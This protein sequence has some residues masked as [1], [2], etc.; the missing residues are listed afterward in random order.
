MARA[1]IEL[2]PFNG[3]HRSEPLVVMPG[4]G[5]R[6]SPPFRGEREGPVAQRREGE[7]GGAARRL[8]GFPHPT[9][10]PG[11]RGE[12]KEGRIVGVIVAG[13]H[14]SAAGIDF[15]YSCVV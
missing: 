7:V 10:S 14:R 2:D 15:Y 1:V 6:P 5:T 12:R 8:V 4:F 11:R 9:L 3:Q 13:E